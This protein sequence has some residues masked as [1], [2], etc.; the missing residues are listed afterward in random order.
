M[1]KIFKNKLVVLSILLCSMMLAYACKDDLNINPA[2]QASGAQ[3]TSIAG[4]NGLLIGA[5]AMLNGRGSIG[6]SVF[7]WVQGGVVGGDA[8]KGSNNGDFGA[9]QP[10]ER[11]ELDATNG[12]TNGKWKA[13][14]E[15]I[16][17]CNQVLH[18]LASADATVSAADKAR[19][20]GEAHFLRG[21]YY[22]ELK[23]TY[24]NTPYVDET[25]DYGTGVDKVKNDQDLW[26][27]IEA[28]LTAAASSL[29]ETQG[30][31]GRANSWAAKA[32]LGKVYLFEKKFP[33][34][35]TLFTSVI[36]SGKTSGGVAYSLL[37]NFPDNFNAAT[38]NNSETVFSVQAAANS[39]SSNTANND[40]VLNF[41]YNTGAN[42][43]AGCCGFNQPS[44]ELGNSYRTDAKGLPLLD[45]SYDLPSNAVKN[46]QG[47]ASATAFTP[48]A[49][50]LDPRIDWTIGR[51]GIPYLDWQD[52]PGQDWIRDQPF[53]GPYSPKKMVFYK[54]QDHTLTDGSSWTDGY[55]AINYNVIRYA[56]VLLMAAESEIEAGSLETARGYINQVRKRAANSSTWVSKSGKP[57]ANYVIGTYDVPFTDKSAATSALRFERRLELA[58]EGQRFFDLVRWGVAASTINS[59]L[60]YEGAILTVQFGGATFTAGKNE[61][62]PIPQSQIDLQGSDVLKQNPGY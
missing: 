36:T 27:K 15:G 18:Y 51:R 30:A 7:N 4:L 11:F 48:D 50:N 61:Y 41:P 38:S 33:D 25:V 55:S 12:F 21:L 23:K 10:V 26:P 46:D 37:K 14:Y 20:G 53:A 49:G 22:F 47:I 24:N 62:D 44:I 57:A 60:K 56:D 39:G 35:K 31:V 28:D 8:N 5:Y 16:S 40:L 2:G 32:L 19:I 17:R 54:S 1:K 9:I 6:T 42:G 52:H 43:P 3:F 45:G 59:Y 58:D 13:M 34:A 29:P